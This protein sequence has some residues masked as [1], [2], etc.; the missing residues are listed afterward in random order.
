VSSIGR[1]EQFLHDLPGSFFLRANKKDLRHGYHF[2]YTLLLGGGLASSKSAVPQSRYRINL[3]RPA[4]REVGR[5]QRHEREEERGAAES[6]RVKRA[7]IN[8]RC[9]EEP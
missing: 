9:R 1:S 4:R 5:Q 7:Q 6:Q 3:H 8:R 2:T